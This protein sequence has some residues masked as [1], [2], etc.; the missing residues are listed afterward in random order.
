MPY[1]TC[2]TCRFA[3]N[4]R[5]AYTLESCPRCLA[6][7]RR[8]VPLQASLGDSNRDGR[9]LGHVRDEFARR[10][11]PGDRQRPV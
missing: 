5:Y 4:Q 7:D 9:L 10:A 8:R 6:S 2:P 11:A 3:V 1:L